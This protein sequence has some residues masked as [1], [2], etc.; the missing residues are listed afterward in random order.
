M[1]FFVFLIVLFR[2]FVLGF[3]LCL[4]FVFL[5]LVVVLVVVLGVLCS[6]GLFF[7]EGDFFVCWVFCYKP[8]QKVPNIM[9]SRFFTSA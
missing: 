2:F 9:F 1:G 3:F 5:V 6:F 4:L 8:W 7:C